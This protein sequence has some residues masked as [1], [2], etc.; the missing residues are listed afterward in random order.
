MKYTQTMM[1]AAALVAAGSGVWSGNAQE[2][3]RAQVQTIA[4]ETNG[5]GGLSY[6]RYGNRQIIDA[7]ALAAGITNPSGLRL[8]YNLTADKLQVVMGTN[9]TVVASPITFAEGVS[10][11]KTN[12]TLVELLSWVFLGTNMTASGTLRA[13]EHLHFGTS[14]ELQNFQLTGQLQFATPAA[15]TNPAVVYS[16]SITAASFGLE[17]QGEQ[18]QGDQNQGDQGD[19][20]R[21][22]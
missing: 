22:D 5:S 8:V 14:N 19:R 21:R 13:T 10:L 17:G 20:D 9:N 11:S 1:L 6:S 15:G 16:G 18:D 7:A 12:G 4:V 3:F 2:L